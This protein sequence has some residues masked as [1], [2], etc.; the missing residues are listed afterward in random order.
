MGRH[1]VIVIHRRSLALWTLMLGNFRNLGDEFEL[2]RFARV[3]VKGWKRRGP[4]SFR[5]PTDRERKSLVLE[6]MSI[7]MPPVRPPGGSA[8]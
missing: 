7:N 8:Q 4:W 2:E 6:V 1:E 3:R 5:R